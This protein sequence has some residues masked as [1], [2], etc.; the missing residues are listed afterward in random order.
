MPDDAAHRRPGGTEPGFVHRAGLG[1]QRRDRTDKNRRDLHPIDETT[2]IWDGSTTGSWYVASGQ[3]TID[4]RLQVRGNAYLI[5]ED[6]CVLTINGGIQVEDDDNDPDTPS[7]NSLTIYGQSDQAGTMGR[8]TASINA[9]NASIYHAVIGG[10]GNDGGTITLT[11][12]PDEGYELD[13]LTV[14]DNQGSQRKLTSLGGGKYTFT[15]P[16]GSVTV[17]AV[18]TRILLFVDV[19]KASWYTDAVRYVYDCG[20]MNGTDTD[21]FSPDSTASRAMIATVLWRMAGSPV[22]S[23]ALPFADV[24]DGTWYTESARWASVVGIVGGYRDDAFG[25]DDAVTREQLAAMLMR[26]VELYNP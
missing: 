7:A 15:M 16:S 1:R 20:L 13:T 9:E 8:L 12:T 24:A 17:S 19:D 26:F 23:D 3:V 10:N 21:R 18:F 25:P 2:V 5:L 4:Q 6:T 22:V 11:V 14:T